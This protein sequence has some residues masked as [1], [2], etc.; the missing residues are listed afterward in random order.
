LRRPSIDL[1]LATYE[2]AFVAFK[3]A[4]NLPDAWFEVPDHFAIKCADRADYDQTCDE[5][6]I[7]ADSEGIWELEL[8]DRLLASAGLAN[9]V[10]LA[11]YRFGW[12]E[13]MQPR[14]GKESAAGFVEHT[15]F[16]LPD[17]AEIM[18]ALEE[19]EV[20]YELQENPGHRWL[21]IVIDAHGREI[22]INDKLLADVVAAEKTEGL[23]SPRSQEERP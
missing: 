22:K 18:T 7:M 9:P 3:E 23:L 10:T 14:P 1:E 2:Q 17:F 16:L 6:E 4:N 20:A 21:N 5:L 13:I 11:G 15:E 8:D 12:V 19:R